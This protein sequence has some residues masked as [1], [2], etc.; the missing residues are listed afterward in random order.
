M[1]CMEGPTCWRLSASACAGGCRESKSGSWT[2]CRFG[3]QKAALVVGQ[4]RNC[5][6]TDE[7]LPWPRRD[8]PPTPHSQL[9]ALEW[10]ILKQLGNRYFSGRLRVFSVTETYLMEFWIGGTV[11][12]PPLKTGWTRAGTPRHSNSGSGLWSV[13]PGSQCTASWLNQTY[14]NNISFHPFVN[15]NENGFGNVS[16]VFS[17]FWQANLPLHGGNTWSAEGAECVKSK[18]SE[19]E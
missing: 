13:V 14:S 4:R 18:T 15:W 17:Y 1:L 6:Q 10:F 11:Q 5:M 8:L 2:Q 12:Q 19:T 16:V 3:D 9:D 7:F